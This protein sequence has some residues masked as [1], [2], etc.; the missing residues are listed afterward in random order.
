MTGDLEPQAAYAD[1]IDSER[2]RDESVV[3]AWLE[4]HP[5]FLPG[6]RTLDTNSGHPPWPHAVISSPACCSIDT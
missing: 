6:A 1:L 2:S 4:A 5:S 3:Q